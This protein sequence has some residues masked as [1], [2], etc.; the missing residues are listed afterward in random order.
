MNAVG[1]RA[2]SK[3]DRGSGR[4]ADP[5]DRK[6]EIRLEMDREE[7]LKVLRYLMGMNKAGLT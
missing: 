7:A 4:Q 5:E 6:N 3:A 1:N 2:S